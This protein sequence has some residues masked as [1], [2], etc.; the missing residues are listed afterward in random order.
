MLSV[1]QDYLKKKQ[2]LSEYE[3]PIS[4]LYKDNDLNLIE[5]YQPEFTLEDFDFIEMVVNAQ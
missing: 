4:S 3:V 5:N 2:K 1:C